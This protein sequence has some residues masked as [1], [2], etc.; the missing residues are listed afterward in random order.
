M[1][2]NDISPVEIV[3]VNRRG[4]WLASGDAEYY[5]DF[6]HFPW[7]QKASIETVCEVEEI[8]PGH[9]YWPKLDLDLDLDTIL[10]PDRY[11][12]VDGSPDIS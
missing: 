5:L 7:F 2:G 6:K 1:P 9:F 8:T 10:N 4:L 12:L 3:H 11:P